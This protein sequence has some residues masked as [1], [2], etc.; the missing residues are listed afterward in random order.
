MPPF[1]QVEK[2]LGVL[3]KENK[4]K[5]ARIAERVFLLKHFFE[6]LKEINN[7]GGN[8]KAHLEQILICLNANSFERLAGPA[9]GG[10]RQELIKLITEQVDYLTKE[11]EQVESEMV[12]VWQQSDKELKDYKV[13]NEKPAGIV[14]LEE[15]Q[16]FLIGTQKTLQALSNELARWGV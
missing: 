9:N 7:Q 4:E 15:R 2:P 11:L 8:G 3:F 5:Q 1:E 16:T 14:E 13:G 6:S 12:T 10:D